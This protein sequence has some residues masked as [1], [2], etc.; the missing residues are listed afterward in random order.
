M[1]SFL[2]SLALLFWAP[3]LWAAELPLDKLVLPPG[4]SINVYADVK[5][6]RQMTLGKN[7]TVYVGSMHFRGGDGEIFALLNPDNKPAAEKVVVINKGLVMP[8]GVAYRDGDLYV[9]AVRHLYR[10]KNIDSTYGTN[11]TPEILSDKF[12]D[13]SHHGWKFINFGPDGLLYVPVGAPCNICLSEEAIFGTITRLDVDSKDRKIEIFAEGIRNSVGFDWHPKT[14]KLWFTDNGGDSLGD[15]I[16]ADELNRVTE[17]GQHF[18]YPFFHEGTLP[19]KKFGKGKKAEDYTPPAQKLGAHVAA[20]G[21]TFYDGK[22]F[23]ERF[24]NQIIIPEGGSWNRTKKAGHVGSR[25]T[26]VTLEGNKAVKYEPF[27]TGW[28]DK[29]KNKSWGHPTATLVLPD[30]SLLVAD[31]EAN[32]VYRVTYKKP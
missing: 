27:I 16:P 14:G 6:A 20:L 9:G 12:P 8:S 4:F 17:K 21:M 24:R 1:K 25:L 3:V 28:L 10:Y 32:V 15:N 29:T 19:D 13:K 23:P 7:G 11:P 18:G 30:G 31:N 2:V 26:L 22:M 5:H